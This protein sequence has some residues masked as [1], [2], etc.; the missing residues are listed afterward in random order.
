LTSHICGSNNH[1][2]E[3]RKSGQSF[4]RNKSRCC[5]GTFN[6][7]LGK[8]QQSWEDTLSSSAHPFIMPGAGPGLQRF[9]EEVGGGVLASANRFQMIHAESKGSLILHR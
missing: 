9:V 4:N 2:G 5:R 8:S 7:V 1:G 3:R 6:Q